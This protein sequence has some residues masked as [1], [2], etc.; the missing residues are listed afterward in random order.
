MA[1]EFNIIQ[2]RED[3]III[4]NPQGKVESWNAHHEE[5]NTGGGGGLVV[6]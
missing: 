6:V 5:G 2:W 1:L 3:G 4:H